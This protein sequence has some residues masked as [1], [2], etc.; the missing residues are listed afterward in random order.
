MR[1]CLLI[2]AAGTL[3]AQSAFEVATIKPAD[4][5]STKGWR[6]GC[7]G[8]D[9]KAEGDIVDVPTG[10]CVIIDARLSHMIALAWNLRTISLIQNAPAWAIDSDEHWNVQAKS[11]DPK[12]TEA[13]MLEMLRGLLVDRFHLKYHRENHDEPGY[14]LLVAKG[15]AK[16]Q[17]SKDSDVTGLGPFNK[18][19]YPAVHIAPRRYSMAALADFL[20]WIGPGQT[21]DETGLDGFYNFDL[22]WNDTDGPSVFSAIQKIGLRLEAR[23]VPVSYFVIDSA[24]RPGEN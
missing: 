17:Q 16:M 5:G 24:Q 18:G 22:S 3:C 23:K 8:I 2:F 20:S 6:G 9:S 1:F 11:E 15:G 19:S 12:A 21:T 7:R 4:P 14:A 10:R 13:Q